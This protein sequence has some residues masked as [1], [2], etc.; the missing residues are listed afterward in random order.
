M[1]TILDLADRKL[2]A[3]IISQD[4]TIQNTIY[5]TWSKARAIREITQ[6]HIFHSDRG[7]QY[8][9]NQMT[10]LLSTSKKITQTM[11]RKEN[12]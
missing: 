7:V 11:S 5:K 6:N 3:W 12:F 8:A 2:I 1:T 4:M 9:S 10:N